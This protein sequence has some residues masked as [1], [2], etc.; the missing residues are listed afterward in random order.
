MKKI[1]SYNIIQNKYYFETN[2]LNHQDISDFL[3]KPIVSYYE[4][5]SFKIHEFFT[6]DGMIKLI[7]L[8]KKTESDKKTSV[9]KK[10]PSPW[11]V[12]NF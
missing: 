3:T 9:S 1:K 8:Y 7:L 12:L 11:Y 5:F 2:E 6:A 4:D 10:F